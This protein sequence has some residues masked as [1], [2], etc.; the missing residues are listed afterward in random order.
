VKDDDV[1]STSPAL[2]E[3]VRQM[4]ERRLA[5]GVVWWAIEEELVGDESD[6]TSA[7]SLH[8]DGCTVSLG[9]DTDVVEFGLGDPEA[10]D[11]WAILGEELRVIWIGGDHLEAVRRVREVDGRIIRATSLIGVQRWVEGLV[12]SWRTDL[13]VVHDPDWS[14]HVHPLAWILERTV[15]DAV[16]W[17]LDAEPDG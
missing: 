5:G 3:R 4:L 2:V 8:E 17:D 9:A 15:D 14:H 11:G 10:P 13:A 7:W 1:P 16:P 12:A 6:P